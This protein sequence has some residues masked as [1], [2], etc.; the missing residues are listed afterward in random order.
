MVP[1]VVKTVRKMKI[2]NLGKITSSKTSLICAMKS[3]IGDCDN[4]DNK[5]I[6]RIPHII[7]T[8]WFQAV[9]RLEKT[10]TQRI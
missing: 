4:A 1:I 7:A 2:R 9:L 10:V 8:L 5:L 6:E 3:M